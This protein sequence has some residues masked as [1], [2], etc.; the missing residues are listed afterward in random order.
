MPLPKTSIRTAGSNRSL[1]RIV[2]EVP[3]AYG[4]RLDLLAAS[5]S[6]QFTLFS[7]IRS[8]WEDGIRAQLDAGGFN[9]DQAQIAR[10]ILLIGSSMLPRNRRVRVANPNDNGEDSAE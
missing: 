2:G 10:E 7:I 8:W 1:A 6:S 5:V 9:E 3:P 4:E